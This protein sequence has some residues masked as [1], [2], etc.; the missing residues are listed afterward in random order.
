MRLPLPAAGSP[1]AAREMRLRLEVWDRDAY[2]SDDLVAK[3]LSGLYPIVTFQ[4]SST[5][6]YR[7]SY[8]IR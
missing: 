7:V 2:S 6:L 3:A 8:H 5:T 1:L 4:Y